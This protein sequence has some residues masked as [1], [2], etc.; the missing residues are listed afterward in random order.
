MRNPDPRI[1]Q[2]HPS[3]VV[4]GELLSAGYRDARILG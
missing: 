2:F 4:S 3:R 1:A